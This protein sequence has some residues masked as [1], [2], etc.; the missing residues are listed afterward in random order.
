MFECYLPLAEKL[1]VPVIG[2]VT[3]RSWTLADAVMGNPNNPG[4][5]PSTFSTFSDKMTFLERLQNLWNDIYIHY[6]YNFEVSKRLK[7]INDQFYTEDLLNKKQVSLV[8]INNHLS[9]LPKLSGTNMI[10]VGGIHV[11][12]AKPLPEVNNLN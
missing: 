10:D 2:T 8:F 3:W 11:R 1:N 5:I 9:L 4:Q 12:P 7:K 6:K